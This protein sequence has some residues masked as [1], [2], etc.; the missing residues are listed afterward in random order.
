MKKWKV[1][2]FVLSSGCVCGLGWHC[3]LIP[4]LHIVSPLAGLAT[5]LGL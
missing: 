5:L 1:A 3:G 2:L 4:S